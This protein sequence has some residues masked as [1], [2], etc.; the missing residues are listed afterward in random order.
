MYW[1]SVNQHVLRWWLY[2]LH[3]SQLWSFS[4]QHGSD[5]S[6][7]PSF[8]FSPISF[9]S[10]LRFYASARLSIVMTKALSRAGL[11]PAPLGSKEKDIPS[12]LPCILIVTLVT[13]FVIQRKRPR[14]HPGL[15]FVNYWRI[16]NSETNKI[17]P[18]TLFHPPSSYT[19][20][21]HLAGI[22]WIP[23][24]K[25]DIHFYEPSCTIYTE[26]NLAVPY[27]RIPLTLLNLHISKKK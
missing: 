22:D 25:K 19:D 15:T 8:S 27:R 16:L 10:V 24:K 21:T 17:S 3:G 18:K 26:T 12:E 9:F 14:L 6:I 23:K 20:S 4:G 5:L 11:E 1:L 13:R 2:C 7:L